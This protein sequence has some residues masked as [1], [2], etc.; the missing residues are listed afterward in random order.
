[1]KNLFYQ[2]ILISLLNL[3]SCNYG[4]TN[5]CEPSPGCPPPSLSIGELKFILLDSN[6]QTIEL[7]KSDVIV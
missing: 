1:M 2:L 5:E 7:T 6:N 3:W 4:I